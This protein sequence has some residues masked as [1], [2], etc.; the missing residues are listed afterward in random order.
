MRGREGGGE[1]E[2]TFDGFGHG[3]LWVVGFWCERL[4]RFSWM[5][6]WIDG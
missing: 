1:G 2:S 3:G 6:R 4:G 5:D